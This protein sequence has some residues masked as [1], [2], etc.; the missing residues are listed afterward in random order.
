MPAGQ[1]HCSY[2]GCNQQIDTCK[3]HYWDCTG[4]APNEHPNQRVFLNGACQRSFYVGKIFMRCGR[5]KND[6]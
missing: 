3:V 6:P 4:K 5:K 1:H 2:K